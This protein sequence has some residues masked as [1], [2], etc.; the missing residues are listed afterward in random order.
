ML[1]DS[2]AEEEDEVD[3]DMNAEEEE[4]E[5]AAEAEAEAVAEVVRSSSG[6]AGSQLEIR[7]EASFSLGMLACGGRQFDQ[8]PP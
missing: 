6:Q 5:A 7:H 4:E 2:E 3:A 1:A 8:T